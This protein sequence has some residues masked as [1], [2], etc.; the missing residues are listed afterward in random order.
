MIMTGGVLSYQANIGSGGAGA[1]NLG[2]GFSKQYREDIITISLRT[3]SVS[4]G[5]VLTEVLVT[6]TVLS[7]ALDSDVFRFVSQGTELIEIEGG[8]VRNEPMSVALQ[9]AIETAVLETIRE[10]VD[11]KYWRLKQ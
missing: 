10:G 5:R 2:I 9:I 3:V 4:T 11:K 1:R 7:A 6:K 8:N